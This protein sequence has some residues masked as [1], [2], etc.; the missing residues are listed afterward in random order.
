MEVMAQ[1]VPGPAKSTQTALPT[2]MQ[3][4]ASLAVHFMEPDDS[5]S[6]SHT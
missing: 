3:A 6:C 2:A 5:I 1:P 4:F